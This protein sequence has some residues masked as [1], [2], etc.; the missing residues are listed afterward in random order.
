MNY[1]NYYYAEFLNTLSKDELIYRSLLD[2]KE[3]SSNLNIQKTI[4]STTLEE[5]KITLVSYINYLLEVFSFQ[6]YLI[7]AVNYK[8]YFRDLD[9]KYF[10]ISITKLDNGITIYQKDYNILTYLVM[11]YKY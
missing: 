10:I 6:I 9:K 5:L 3:E 2:N 1:Y 11:S 7:N 4:L 8:Y